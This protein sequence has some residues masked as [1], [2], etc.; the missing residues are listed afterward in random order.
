M[1]ETAKYMLQLKKEQADMFSAK[2]NEICKSAGWWGSGEVTALDL[3]N[4]GVL[5]DAHSVFVRPTV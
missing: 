5:S 4:Q 3:F 1:V 2:I